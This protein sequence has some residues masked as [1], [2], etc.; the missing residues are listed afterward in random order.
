M[1]LTT[2]IDTYNNATKKQVPEWGSGYPK[3]G[4]VTVVC[5]LFSFPLYIFDTQNAK[6][7][8]KEKAKKELKN[9]DNS[10]ER[11]ENVDTDLTNNLFIF[12]MINSKN[13]FGNLKSN[14]IK[15]LLEMLITI[16]NI[17]YLAMFWNTPD[18]VNTQYYYE[19]PFFNLNL[20]QSLE[21]FGWFNA[22]LLLFKNM[23][24][25]KQGF[26]ALFFGLGSGSKKSYLS[27][28]NFWN[29]LGIAYYY[30]NRVSPEYDT[31]YNSLNGASTSGYSDVTT[32]ITKTNVQDNLYYFLKKSSNISIP[33]SA[34]LY[35][36]LLEVI[37]S[38]KAPDLFKDVEK[39]I[40][41]SSGKSNKTQ[42]S[43]G[44]RPPKKI[45]SNWPNNLDI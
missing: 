13:I 37:E 25:Q 43:G 34:G 16:I 20:N 15:K 30:N 23:V 3:L 32:A 2:D 41:N 40:N 7:F 8:L 44:G 36:I 9:K 28:L 21:N 39:I 1:S 45:I 29:A 18:N 11:E 27:S 17:L 24:L 33:A 31:F 26:D 42:S 12:S 35:F 6:K 38:Q 5:I 14:G 19:P 4:L 10:N 22:G